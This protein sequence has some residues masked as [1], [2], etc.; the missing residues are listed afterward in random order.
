[1]SFRVKPIR[2]KSS[3]RVRQPNNNDSAGPSTPSNAPPT[4]ILTTHDISRSHNHRVVPTVTPRG[5]AGT[6][7]FP[8]P[9]TFIPRAPPSPISHSPTEQVSD[10]ADDRGASPPGPSV[11]LKSARQHATWSS[12]VIPSL[13]PMYLHLLRTTQS[14]TRPPVTS[15]PLCI[16]GG[17]RSTLY[18][19]CL[20]FDGAWAFT[21]YFAGSDSSAFSTSFSANSLLSL[22]LRTS[23]TYAGWLIPL[24]SH[25][26]HTRCRHQVIGICP[27]AISHHGT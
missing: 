17:K 20:H 26:A 22:Q 13:V 21:M 7:T 15:T 19:V 18:I 23:T 25:C 11:N 6:Y 1:M 10:Q 9:P 14:F 27:F 5:V 4:R 3:G 16:C 24:R 12:D 2:K 8:A